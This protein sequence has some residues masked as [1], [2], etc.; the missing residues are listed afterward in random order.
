MSLLARLCGWHVEWWPNEDRMTCALF[1]RLERVAESE[2]R[3]EANRW[4]GVVRASE[5]EARARQQRLQ[6]RRR[7]RRVA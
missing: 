2:A 7:I 4:S 5:Q 1:R 6:V 3:H